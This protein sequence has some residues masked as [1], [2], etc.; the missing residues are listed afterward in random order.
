[1]RFEGLPPGSSTQDMPPDTIFTVTEIYPTHVVLD[2][3][4]PLAGMALRLHLKVLDVRPAS[5]E[6]VERGSVGDAMVRLGPQPP[7][8]GTPLH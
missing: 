3:N 7:P 8:S 5:V 4:H 1:M 2:G 6:E